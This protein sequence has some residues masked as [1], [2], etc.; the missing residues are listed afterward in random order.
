MSAVIQ[1]CLTRKNIKYGPPICRGTK[2]LMANN[3]MH[4]DIK[5]RRSFPVLLNAAG[6]LRRYAQLEFSI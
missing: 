1:T 6:D 5:K 4:S 2:L 3:R